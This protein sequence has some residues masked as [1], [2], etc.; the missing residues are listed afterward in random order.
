MKRTIVLFLS[1]TLLAAAMFAPA[2]SSTDATPA[3]PKNNPPAG[4]DSG[5]TTPTVDASTGDGGSQQCTG[6]V[7]DNTRIP[8]WPNVPQ[9]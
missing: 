3:G 9:P 1:S 4:T 7:F 6:P 2:C 5:T 8:G